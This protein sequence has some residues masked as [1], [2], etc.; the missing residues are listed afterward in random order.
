[1]NQTLETQQKDRFS[2]L[3]LAL[4]L[5]ADFKKELAMRF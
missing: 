4:S 2:F 3:W 1:M 5:K